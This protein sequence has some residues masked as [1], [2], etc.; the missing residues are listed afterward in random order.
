MSFQKTL[1]GPVV[2]EGRGLHTGQPVKAVVKP[3]AVNTGIHFCR[4]DLDP[5]FKAKA[6]IK[7]V[8][9]D[10][11]RQTALR[12]G[13][14]VVRTIEHVMGALHGLGIDNAEIEVDGDEMPAMDGSA[15]DFTE[16]FLSR[17]LREQ[18]SPRRYLEIKEPLYVDSG[19]QSVIALPAPFFSISYT[20]SYRHEDLKDQFLSLR[21]LPEIFERELAPARTFCLKQEAEALLAQGFGKGANL[22]NTLVFEKNAPLE[23]TLR[24]ENEACRHKMMDL[25]GDLYLAGRPIRGHIIA[26]RSGHAL[27]V[28]MVKKI[29]AACKEDPMASLPSKLTVQD[30]QKII[31]HRYPFLFVDRIDHF[32]PGECATGFKLVSMNDYF[33]QGHFPG[34]PVMPGVLIIEAMAQVGGVIMLSKPENRNKIAYFMSIDSAKFRHP[35]V[36]GDEL[37]FEIKVQKIRA[38]TGQCAGQAFVGDKLV[39]EAE[40][41]FAVV[42]P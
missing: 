1:Q 20:L 36:P 31:P 19:N 16:S 9:S 10:E 5:E 14:G 8:Q 40:V 30:I 11:M 24:F 26:V 13:T 42:E 33:F 29:I 27:N 23:N 22:T 41:K 4:I 38:K 32:V 35:V 7:N 3:A 12:V 6:S 2:F 21:I 17:G 37:R 25:L 18:E 28:E 39:C 34:H 15:K